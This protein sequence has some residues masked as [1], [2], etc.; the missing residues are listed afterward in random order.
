MN[1][2]NASRMV[3]HKLVSFAIVIALWTL[4]TLLTIFLKWKYIQDQNYAKF[5]L[6]F[7]L[8]SFVLVTRLERSYG[9]IFILVNMISVTKTEI[10]V[11]GPARHLI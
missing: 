2:R 5:I 7:S 9:E 11:T 8:K 3:E 6:L 4:V 10:S 1:S